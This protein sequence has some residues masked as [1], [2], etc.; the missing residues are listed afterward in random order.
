M[1]NGHKAVFQGDRV[2]PGGT[3]G[4]NPKKVKQMMKQ[5][6]VSVKQL[7]DVEEVIIKT[8]D[9]E[10]IFTN[11][12]VAVMDAMGVKTYQIV[13]TPEERPKE[14]VI[15]EGDVK[16][17]IEQ[18]GVSEEKALSALKEAKGD[19]AEAIMKLSG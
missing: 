7:E 5:M 6:G 2:F 11:A 4:M 17:V 14:E 18:T 9:S 3:R 19:L 16:L 13:G 8:A 10:I 1:T 15:P 12:E